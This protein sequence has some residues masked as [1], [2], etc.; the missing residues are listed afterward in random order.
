MQGAARQHLPSRGKP[1]VTGRPT[2][3][4]TVLAFRRHPG[5]ART[6]LAAFQNAA[7]RRL[8]VHAYANVPYYRALFDQSGLRLQDI[9]GTA[10]LHRIPVTT[11]QVLQAYSPEYLVARGRDPD[12]LVKAKTSGSSGEPFTIRRTWLEQG[13]QYLLRIRAFGQ[14]G[15]RPRDRIAY[16]QAVHP[17]DPKDKKFIGRMLSALGIGTILKVD[18]LQE[19]GEVVRRLDGFQPDVLTGMP[20]MLCRLAEYL[21]A[22]DWHGLRP[23][24][25]VVGGEVLTPLMRRRLEEAFGVPVHNTYG[26]H[27]VP[28]LGWE[29]PQT[30]EFH[31]C[32]DGVILEVLCDGRPVAPGGRG[33]V[34]V[35]NL[36]AYAM[37]FIRYRLGDVVTRGG[38]R[39]ACGQPFST[40]RAVQ[41]RM[42]DYFLLP[43]GRLLHPYQIVA[44]L[45]EDHKL[46]FRQYQ[47]V[48]ERMNRIILR[49][50][51]LAP[52]TA[53]QIAQVERLVFPLLG[54]GVE[55]RVQVVDDIPLDETGKFRP[56]RSLVHSDYDGIRWDETTGD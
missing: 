19:P 54:P 38:E 31:V 26:S 1:E 4:R 27:E 40:I 10:D 41:G 3:L 45:V 42:I 23:R 47:L 7:L 48:Q 44:G 37:P 56:S 49:V 53:E 30:G 18:G 12:Q 51:P 52:P 55:F 15:L 33:E 35:T 46:W 24:F 32:D 6:E 25:V 13:L 29:C 22:C 39:C 21:L 16:V 8:V 17:P 36:H 14:F 34:V 43:D 20:G 11:K 5:A 2:L 28:L 50:V 9:R